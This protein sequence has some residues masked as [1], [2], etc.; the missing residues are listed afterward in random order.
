M[1]TATDIQ[2][3]SYGPIAEGRD[4]FGRSRTGTG[5]SLAFL[6]PALVRFSRYRDSVAEGKVSIVVVSPIKELS[7]QLA[8]VASAL[9]ARGFRG[10][11]GRP[12]AVRTVIG[13]AGADEFSRGR[14]CDL[15]C[16][17]PGVAHAKKGGGLARL[18]M[19]D[20]RAAARLSDVRTMVLDE[21]DALTAGGFLS[22]IREIDSRV[23]RDAS[24]ASGPGRY[25]LLVFS[26]TLPP[27]LEQSRMM[28]PRMARLVKADTVGPGHKTVGA[29]VKQEAVVASAEH[30]TQVLVSVLRRHIRRASQSGGDDDAF[31]R[32]L[33]QQLS[34]TKERFADFVGSPEILEA[35]RAMEPPP[36]AAAPAAGWKALVFVG[37]AVYVDYTHEAI[38]ALMPGVLALKIHG[39]MSPGSRKRASDAFRDCRDCVLVSTDASARGLDYKGITAVVQVGFSTRSE[40]I[41]RAGRVGRAGAAGHAVALYDTAEA[42]R[43][44]RP[45]CAPT[46]ETCIGDLAESGGMA[47]MRAR[48]GE[49][50]RSS[51]TGLTLG[52]DKD[53]AFRSS[54]Q[55]RRLFRAWAGGLASNFKRL[56]VP[57]ADAVGWAERFASG[58]GASPTREEIR[59]LL[60]A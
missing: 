10:A 53:E 54:V 18:L 21:G 29:N 16:C 32:R 11:G 41:Q 26:A 4:V 30:H 33:E 8:G 45:G 43:V 49:S 35:I 58:V 55:A 31:R 15:L 38:S 14:P 47:V 25:Q 28:R 19:T 57:V 34:G 52:Y 12:F 9:T 5:K 44:L 7:L 46:D 50:G 22:A 1:E 56:K 6:V 2:R 40:F 20:P 13:K 37:S 48:A 24:G 36:A 59:K 27:D 3:L 60:N 23:R 39:G 17:T 51:A 42:K